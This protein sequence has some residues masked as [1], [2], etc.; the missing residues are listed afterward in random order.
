M[1]RLATATPMRATV[2]NR[3]NNHNCDLYDSVDAT[4]PQCHN[5]TMPRCRPL[6]HQWSRRFDHIGDESFLEIQ[7][8]DARSLISFQLGLGVVVW[9]GLNRTEA[10]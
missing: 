8:A 10:N 9:T 1:S 7:L 5:A 3:G 2:F 6:S 4:M